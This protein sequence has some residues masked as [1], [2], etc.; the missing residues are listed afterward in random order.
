MLVPHGPSNAF[1]LARKEGNPRPIDA[2]NNSSILVQGASA[3]KKAQP[4]TQV[5]HDGAKIQ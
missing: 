2:Q 1:F 3:A 5:K 4:A